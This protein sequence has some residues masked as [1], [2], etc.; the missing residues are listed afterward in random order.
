MLNYST[1]ENVRKEIKVDS[2]L[3]DGSSKNYWVS[4]RVFDLFYVNTNA[5]VNYRIGLKHKLR[6]G[7]GVERLAMVQSNMS[8]KIGDDTG[9][10]TVNNNWG[11]KRGIAQWDMR[12]S[13]GYE[14]RLNKKLSMNIT[15]AFGLADRTANDFYSLEP[16]NDREMNIMFGVKYNL[17]TRIR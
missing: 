16:I 5:F 15:G 8:Y 2:F 9:L 12:C 14:Y 11:V 6:F 10:E 13:L 3:V 7:L 17:L 4:L 1:H